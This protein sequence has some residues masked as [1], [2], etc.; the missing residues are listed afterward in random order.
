MGTQEL[1]FK[2]E[3]QQLLNLMIHSVYSDRD[4]FLRELVSNAADALDKARF[5]SLT[6]T[7]LIE[8]AGESAGIRV[9][10]DPDKG[11]VTID[12]DDGA[13]KGGKTPTPPPRLPLLPRYHKFHKNHNFQV[14]TRAGPGRR[15]GRASALPSLPTL[16]IIP[17]IPK[18][19]KCPIGAPNL[20]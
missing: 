19:T 14:G 15:R 5:L 12:D 9:T 3:V 11:I 13:A 20:W 2:A 1:G 10:I 6:R 7:D 17:T 18:T 16:T 8:A 4:V